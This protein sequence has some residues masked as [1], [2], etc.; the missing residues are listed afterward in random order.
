MYSTNKHS[1]TMYV[2]VMQLSE[3]YSIIDSFI[4]VC[5]SILTFLNAMLNHSFV[6][7]FLSNNL[8]EF[9]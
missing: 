9:Y 7:L 2:I 3:C 6:T 1:S 4:I 5:I 8:I